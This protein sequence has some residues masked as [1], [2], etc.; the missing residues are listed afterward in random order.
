MSDTSVRRYA[1]V[2][3][4][5]R[6]LQQLPMEVVKYGDLTEQAMA[7]ALR[8]VRAAIFPPP[9]VEASLAAEKA[10]R[11]PHRKR[12]RAGPTSASSCDALVA[13]SSLGK[14]QQPPAM[15]SKVRANTA[16]SKAVDEAKAS[17]AKAV[18][19][20]MKGMKAGG[21]PPGMKAASSMKHVRR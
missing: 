15:K 10:Q 3:V 13:S 8:G 21:R 6:F 20:V 19:K 11:R 17:E 2:G 18:Q 9:P 14:R 16:G 5:Q 12:S 4:A 7:K 1:K